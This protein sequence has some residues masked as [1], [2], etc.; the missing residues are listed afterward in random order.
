MSDRTDHGSVCPCEACILARMVERQRKELASLRDSLAREKER[1]DNAEKAYL[2]TPVGHVI[3]KLQ[4]ERDALRTRLEE[5]WE[6]LQ[7]IT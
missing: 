4:A 5:A 2:H 1:A 6:K 7:W 3:E